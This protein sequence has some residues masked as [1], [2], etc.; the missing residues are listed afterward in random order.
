MS[1][2]TAGC[3]IHAITPTGRVLGVV[4]SAVGLIFFP[5]FT[6]FLTHNYSDQL[7]DS[8]ATSDGTGG[9]SSKK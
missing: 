3:S 4:L 7:S 8:D 6:V 1:L 5:I 9:E 2:T